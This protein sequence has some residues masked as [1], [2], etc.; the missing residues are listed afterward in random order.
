MY[1]CAQRVLAIGGSYK[2][3]QGINS[4]L[5]LHGSYE[6]SGPPAPDWL[7]DNNPGIITDSEIE[8]PPPGNRVRSYLD[9]VA[10]DNTPLDHLA[11][12]AGRPGVV[13]ELPVIWTHENIWC[14][15]GTEDTLAPQ[16]QHELQRLLARIILLCRRQAPA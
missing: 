15:F 6:W 13:R 3:R 9:L 4:F 14:R 8:I 16:W 12:A 11:Q 10:P 1:V 7:P 5:Y 2:G